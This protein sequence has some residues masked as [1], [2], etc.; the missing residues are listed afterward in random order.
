MSGKNIENKEN[1]NNN[2]SEKSVNLLKK[3]ISKQ[4]RKSGEYVNYIYKKNTREIE[5]FTFTY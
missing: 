4:L 2:W 1:N 5:I 3:S